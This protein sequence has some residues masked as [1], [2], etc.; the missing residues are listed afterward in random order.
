[1]TVQIRK[2]Y[3]D[4]NPEMLFD[5][6]QGLAQRH[7]IKIGETKVQT[8]PLPS[9]STQTRIMMTVKTQGEQ[10]QDEKECGDA[11]II[12]SPGGETKLLL[13]LN[14]NIVIKENISSL[15]EDINFTLDSYEIKW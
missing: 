5:E 8:Y 3:R 12:S 14:E 15:Q 6:I 1:M 13:D 4:I 9:G 11:Q 10:P 7:G 2:T